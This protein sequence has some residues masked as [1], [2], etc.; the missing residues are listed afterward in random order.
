MPTSVFF[1][2]QSDRLEKD[3]RYFIEDALKTAIET[4]AQDIELQRAVREDLTFDKDTKDEPGFVKIFETILAKI[5][6][7]T[8]FVPDFTFVATRPKREPTPNP[9]VLI[10]YGYALKSF[11]ER[12]ERRIM[13]VMNIAYGAPT[14][15]TMPFDL[16]EHRNAITYNLPEKADADTRKAQQKE[17]IK[18]FENAL[19]AFFASD[20]YKSSLPK[21]APVTFREPLQGRARFRQAGKPIGVAR[22]IMAQYT[23]QEGNQIYLEDGPAIWLRVGPQK[24]LEPLM[25]VTEIEDRV[26]ALAVLPLCEASDFPTLVWNADGCGF[27]RPVGDDPS[28]TVAYMFTDG[29]IWA[30]STLFLHW[31]P[32]FILLE[33]ER[34]AETLK[35]CAALLNMI[36]IPGPYRWVAGAEGIENRYLPSRHG[37]VRGPGPCTV[38]IVEEPGTFNV[39]DD[40]AKALEPFFAEVFDKCRARRNVNS[41]G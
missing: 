19:K 27:V 33:E 40:P 3:C 5:E 35:Q 17:L 24:P 14:R 2:W 39:G 30:I 20:F 26:T 23:G 34:Y 7:A 38:D 41:V 6:R 15:E 9:N 37:L 18:K 12:G 13:P 28:P 10:E 4:L 16:I 21:P 11:G 29:E 25:K 31:Y 1:S 8:V 32:E 22:A 36:S